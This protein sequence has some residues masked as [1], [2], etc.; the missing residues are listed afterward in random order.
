MM[1]LQD[2]LSASNAE[3]H[4]AREKTSALEQKLHAL[5]VE[6]TL[7]ANAEQR[8]TVSISEVI[9]QAWTRQGLQDF[10]KPCH[11]NSQKHLVGLSDG[12]FKKPRTRL[13]STMVRCGFL[14]LR[15]DLFALSMLQLL[16]ISAESAMNLLC[17]KSLWPC[18]FPQKSM[19]R[20]L[21]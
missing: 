19:Q 8:L 20:R 12:E 17:C 14:L 13:I 15:S 16:Q 7:A 11:H 1:N 3:A 21:T 2:R 6:K 4:Q 18:R 10:A 5:E 9:L